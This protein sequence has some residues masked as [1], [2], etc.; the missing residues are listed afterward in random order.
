M[1]TGVAFSTWEV[2]LAIGVVPII[3]GATVIR[4]RRSQGNA[5]WSRMVERVVQRSDC[6][7]A[8][9]KHRVRRHPT[10]DHPR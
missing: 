10:G 5:A 6:R 1:S 3:V 8:A 9:R 7:Q 4:G 2:I